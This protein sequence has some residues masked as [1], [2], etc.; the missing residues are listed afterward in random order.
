M[1]QR[2]LVGMS[3]YKTVCRIPRPLVQGKPGCLMG[4]LRIVR[5]RKYINHLSKRQGFYKMNILA[6]IGKR[7]DCARCNDGALRF[8][9][10]HPRRGSEHGGFDAVI[11]E[12]GQAAGG[13]GENASHR[14]VVVKWYEIAFLEADQ[15]DLYVS[16]KQEIQELRRMRMQ[17]LIAISSP[18]ENWIL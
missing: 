12:D 4:A 1:R 16:T 15:A 10:K 2:D 17:V 14:R 11:T 8:F 5:R 13:A 7:A 6:Y 9:Q 18:L 3:E